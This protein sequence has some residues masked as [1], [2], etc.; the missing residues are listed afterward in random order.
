MLDREYQ[1][2]LLH[3]LHEWH[4]ICTQKHGYVQHCSLMAC[5]TNLSKVGLPGQNWTFIKVC[6]LNFG[7][8]E[9]E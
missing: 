8:T 6:V 1:L 9:E 5:G 3:V 7:A 2:A 4:S